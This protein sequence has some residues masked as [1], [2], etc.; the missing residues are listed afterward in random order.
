[1]KCDALYSGRFASKFDLGFPGR[2]IYRHLCM[3]M[4]II[5]CHLCVSLYI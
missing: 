2:Q 1:M 3:C 5:V 4:R